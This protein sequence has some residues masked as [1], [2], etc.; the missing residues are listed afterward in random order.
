MDAYDFAPDPKE[1]PKPKNKKGGVLVR[2]GTI[3]FLVS[4]LCLAAFYVYIYLNPYSSLNPLPPAPP[5]AAV[6]ASPTPETAAMAAPSATVE[7]LPTETIAPTPS[8]T[9][10]AEQ[11][12][13]PPL[14]TATEVVMMTSTPAGTLQPMYFVAE[15]G[16]PSYISHKD[17]C[18]GVYV[19]GY[20]IDAADTPLV[21]MI[22]RV[23][24]T[25]NGEPVDIQ[26]LSGSNTNYTESG[27]EIKLSDNLVDSSETLMVALYRQGYY[28]PVSDVVTINTH[29]S[30]DQNLVVV[31]F[32]QGEE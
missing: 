21:H 11:A 32:V 19:A 12:T 5:T 2:L 22:V 14:P 31:N 10:P 16:S 26:V 18:D 29:A 20:V 28:E 8:E 15:A 9:T 13:L 23:V 25:L 4:A 3:Y 27:W 17:S 6:A 7:A 1:P 24:G 30:C